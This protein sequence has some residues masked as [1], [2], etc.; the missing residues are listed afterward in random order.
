M[1]IT[2]KVLS[3]L[4]VFTLY[5]IFGMC[6]LFLLGKLLI[7]V[8]QSKSER[9]KQWETVK[10]EGRRRQSQGSCELEG[11]LPWTASLLPHPAT[12]PCPMEQTAKN[13]FWVCS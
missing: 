9:V 3:D 13:W 8:V 5:Y 4:I 6:A 2:S 12:L 1:I 10:A 11:A 7:S